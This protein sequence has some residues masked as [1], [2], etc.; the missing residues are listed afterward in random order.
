LIKI[1]GKAAVEFRRG[2]GRLW[3]VIRRHLARIIHQRDLLLGVVQK[4]RQHLVRP[5]AKVVGEAF[6]CCL[7]L[8]P[9]RGVRC[10]D[11][12]DRIRIHRGEDS[13]KG[14]YLIAPRDVPPTGPMAIS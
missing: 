5:Q 2:L 7:R 1:D 8:P 6:Q 13:A 9:P 12:N 11:H 4:A 3:R 10:L 14:R